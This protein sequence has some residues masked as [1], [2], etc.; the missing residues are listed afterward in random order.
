M[1]ETQVFLLWKSGYERHFRGI[2]AIVEYMRHRS[3]SVSPLAPLDGDDAQV[4]EELQRRI[5]E[6]AVVIAPLE[7]GSRW[8]DAE[9]M[10]AKR[11]RKP[12]LGIEPPGVTLNPVLRACCDR[13][14]KW[15]VN[16]AEIADAIEELAGQH[17]SSLASLARR[18]DQLANLY[19]AESNAGRV[20]LDRG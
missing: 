12:V 19:R 3:L 6:A 9:L 14:I 11:N 8:T 16:A 5:R 7:V 1:S 4:W 10:E 20:A 18:Q 15:R 17:R 2:D 13:M